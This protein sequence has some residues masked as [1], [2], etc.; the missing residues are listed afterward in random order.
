[1]PSA[2]I[3][4]NHSSTSIIGDI[5]CEITIRKKNKPDY[6]KMIANVC[7]TFTVEQLVLLKL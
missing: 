3:K 1:M 7:F 2:C 5:G 4:K 6:A